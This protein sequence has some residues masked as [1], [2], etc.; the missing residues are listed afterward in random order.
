MR[1][2]SI[3]FT[4]VGLIFKDFDAEGSWIAPESTTKVGRI[5]FEPA[6]LCQNR[7]YIPQDEKSNLIAFPAPK[8]TRGGQNNNLHFD[9]TELR[10]RTELFRHLKWYFQTISFTLNSNEIPQF[11]L[12]LIIDIEWPKLVSGKQTLPTV[13]VGKKQHM[14]VIVANP[15]NQPIL[16]DYF[17][18]DPKFSKDTQL[19][20]PLEVVDICTNCYLTDRDVY[21]LPAGAPKKP[22]LIPAAT[23]LPINIEFSANQPDTYSTLLHIRN[24]LTLYEAIWVTSK[25]V[26]SQFK[27]GNRKPGSSTP[28]LFEVNEKHLSACAN[29]NRESTQVEQLAVS[30]VFFYLKNQTSSK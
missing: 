1:I 29:T 15:S 18:S 25:T 19:S 26:Q 4:D 20:L 23:S 5:F 10:R 7:C 3:N 30:I 13:E 9:E 14:Q 17:F 24:N 22:L 6:K 8:E 16:I 28:L 21:S 27:F 2:N 12:Y 11:Q